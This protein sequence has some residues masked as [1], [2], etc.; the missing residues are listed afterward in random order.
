M[1]QALTFERM[2][3]HNHGLVAKDGQSLPLQ[4]TAIQFSINDFCATVTVNQLFVNSRPNPVEADFLF[5]LPSGAAVCAFG[6]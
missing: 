3:K 6:K 2:P 1:F 5:P 4:K